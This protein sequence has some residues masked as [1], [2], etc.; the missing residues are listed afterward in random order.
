M[1]MIF[2]RKIDGVGLDGAGKGVGVELFIDRHIALNAAFLAATRDPPQVTMPLILE[3]ARTE[4]RKLERPINE[5]DFRMM[6][7]VGVKA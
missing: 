7:P 6:E 2:R 4:F 3:A 1:K 5:A